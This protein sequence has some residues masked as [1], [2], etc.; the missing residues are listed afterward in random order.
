MGRAT[1]DDKLKAE[2]KTDQA[3]GKLKQVGEKIKD[4]L[5]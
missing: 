1:D 4:I 3:K 2:G 5:K